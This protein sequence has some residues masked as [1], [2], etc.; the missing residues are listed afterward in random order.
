MQRKWLIG[1][2][3]GMIILVMVSMAV[4]FGSPVDNIEATNSTDKIVTPAPV[5]ARSDAEQ[6]SPSSYS[7][8]RDASRTAPQTATNSN[9]LKARAA[10]LL[11]AAKNGDQN[12][13]FELATIY[14][15]CM[16]YSVN[17]AGY[18]GEMT[19]PAIKPLRFNKVAYAKAFNEQVSRCSGFG[20]GDIHVADLKAWY[21]NAAKGGNINAIA[22]QL[23]RTN[24]DA[25]T[26]KRDVDAVLS[27]RDPSA[28]DQLA[29]AMGLTAEGKEA[30][31]GPISGTE[32]DWYAWK[33]AACDLGL[34][35]GPNSAAADSYCLSMLICG[36]GGVEDIYR[37]YILSGSDFEVVEQKRSEIALLLSKER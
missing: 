29:D 32:R 14:E 9:D 13:Q 8:A 6:H 31:F 27:S 21:A 10:F 36:T 2:T 24:L 25:D 3:I 22:H 34:P 19:D 37:D 7:I 28:V 15:Q 16:S 23:S 17:P 35:C 20:H 1:L 4:W 12:A 5:L 11:L 26:A 30:V 33:L 18:V